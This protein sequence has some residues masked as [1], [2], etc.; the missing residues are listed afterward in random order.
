MNDDKKTIVETSDGTIRGVFENGLYVF[1]GIP[2]AAPPVGENRWLPPQPPATWQGI[3]DARLFGP[4]CPQPATRMGIAVG[5]KEEEEEPQSEDCLFLNVWT[6]GLD[7][8]KRPVM[9]W[10]HGGAFSMGSGSSPMH[11]GST[12]ATRG[13]LICVSLNYRLSSFGFLRLKEITGGR[14]P[15]TGNEG[16]LDQVAALDW[17]RRNIS[18][19][20]GDPDNITVFG[21]SAGAMS[22]GCLLA[23]PAARGLFAKAI[24]QSGANT[25][26]ALDKAVDLSGQFLDI[27]GIKPAETGALRKVPAERMVEAQQELSARMLKL[28]IRGAIL[29]PVV[30]GEILPAFPIDAVKNGSSR[31]ITLMAGSNLEES[32]LLTAGEKNLSKMDEAALVRRLGRMLPGID[33]PNLVSR[34]RAARAKRGAPASPAETF[35]AA[36]TDLQFRI[37][38]VRLA[39]AHCAQNQT[40]Y[41]YLFTWKSAME[42]LGACHAL[43]VGFIFG[44]CNADFHGSGPVVEKLSASM[45]DSWIAF[46][47]TGN[48]SCSALGEWPA[49][50]RERATML[51]GEECRVEKEVFEEERKVWDIVPNNLIGW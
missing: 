20:G 32:R 16:L 49:Y 5:S 51:L 25:A 29:K 27:L 43:D 8:G 40:A 17:V 11:P 48:P 14:I 38:A 36:Q 41:N 35:L 2:Y 21:E 46:A 47:S 7:G 23:M 39:E 12:L 24:M 1:K 15:S 31:G 50:C 42:N 34:Y 45:Q 28:K 44:T 26:K 19:F 3:R 33:V 9:V 30:D 18:A 22:T 6:P 37:P 10:I 4:V 13:N